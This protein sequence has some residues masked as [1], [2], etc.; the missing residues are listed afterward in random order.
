MTG[1][2]HRPALI[3]LQDIGNLLTE[4]APTAIGRAD[5]ST[6]PNDKPDRT[7]S[8]SNVI[9]MPVVIS[10]HPCGHR[11]TVRAGHRQTRS[12]RTYPDPTVLVDQILHDQRRQATERRTYQ[13][14]KTRRS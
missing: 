7:G 5:Q 1:Q 13:V 3:A 4:S 8:H 9:D 10:V 12:P 11:P 2:A 6:D 14:T